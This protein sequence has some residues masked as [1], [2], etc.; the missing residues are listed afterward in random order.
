MSWLL[1]S[2]SLREKIISASHCCCEKDEHNN[3]CPSSLLDCLPEFSR[4]LR[5]THFPSVEIDDMKAAAVFDVALAQ[6]MQLELPLP[7][8]AQVF[9]C[10]FGKEN[11]PGIAAI[12]H[13]LCDVHPSPGHVYLFIE[14]SN[15]VDRPTVNPHPH[16]KFRM[17]F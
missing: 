3:Q 16:V 9:R 12:H 2:Q 5:I 4:H 6:V 10:M 15:F 8:L 11:V 13:P 7:I 1:K 17:L 14:V